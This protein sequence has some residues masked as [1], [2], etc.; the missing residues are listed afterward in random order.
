LTIKRRGIKKPQKQ[1]A[2]KI[3]QNGKKSTR[4][5]NQEIRH[6]YGKKS[7]GPENAP[8]KKWCK[9]KKK[10][11]TR[12]KKER[13]KPPARQKPGGGRRQEKQGSKEPE[14]KDRI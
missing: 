12:R 13:V 2:P 5:K 7:S 1:P 8:L 6:A 9:G 10:K 4:E 3:G 11:N 14:K